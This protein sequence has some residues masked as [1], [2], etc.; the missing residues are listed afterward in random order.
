[1]M[2]PSRPEVFFEHK[3]VDM[4]TAAGIALRSLTYGSEESCAHAARARACPILLS[5]LTTYAHKPAT[6]R[7]VM[8]ALAN[9]ACTKSIKES[10]TRVVFDCGLPEEIQQEKQAGRAGF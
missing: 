7:E 3:N 2:F 4:V 10:R 9:V 1:M 5:T 6:T 8:A